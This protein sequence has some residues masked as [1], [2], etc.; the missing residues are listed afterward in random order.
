MSPLQAR[1]EA[2]LTNKYYW[3]TILRLRARAAAYQVGPNTPYS[4]FNY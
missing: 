2:T 4:K 3:T 1:E